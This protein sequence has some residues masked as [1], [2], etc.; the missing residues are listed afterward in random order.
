MFGSLFIFHFVLPILPC[1]WKTSYRKSCNLSDEKSKMKLLKYVMSQAILITWGSKELY[2]INLNFVTYMC[3]L[4]ELL[5]VGY[6]LIFPRNKS[7]WLWFFL[8]PRSICFV[9]ILFD[10]FF[11]SSQAAP[12]GGILYRSY[13]LQF[14]EYFYCSIWFFCQDCKKLHLKSKTNQL[15]RPYQSCPRPEKGTV[16]TLLG[17]RYG[18]LQGRDGGRS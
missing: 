5:T 12:H 11:D 2:Y 16:H 10:G 9:A 6:M 7:T 18:V 15:D 4:N 13:R 1:K 3:T 8:R 17:T 14:D